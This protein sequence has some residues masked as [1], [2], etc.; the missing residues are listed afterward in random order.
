MSPKTVRDDGPDVERTIVGA[1]FT[2][3]GRQ[4]PLPFLRSAALPGCV[5]AVA[6]AMLRDPRLAPP[7]VNHP[8]EPFWAMFSR[9]L[10]SLDGERHRAMRARFQSLF[11]P[12]QVAAYRAGIERRTR[13]LLDA[14]AGDGEMD[15]VTDF[16]HPLPFGVI[17]EILGVPTERHGWLAERM[18]TIGLGFARQRE[19]E[20]V[21]RASAAA[22]ELQAYYGAELRLRAN[23]A[24]ADS[25]VLSILAANLPDDPE[26]MADIVANCVFFVEAGHATTTALIAGGVLLLLQNPAV[27][28]QLRQE[29][30]LIGNAI[31]EMLRLVSPLAIIPRTPREDAEIAGCPFQ[32]GQTRFVFL[33]GVNR[34][35]DV[36]S[37]PDD[38]ALDRLE[39]RH[40]AFAA[41]PHFCLGA[42]LARLHAEV[43][44]S[45]LLARFPE[46]SLAGEP[47]W[48]GSLPLRQ[49]EALP[50]K[51]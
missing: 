10:V 41:G 23:A 15:V 32:R 37:A 7:G 12:R 16:A 39:N 51:W 35:P 3:E 6:D 5:H 43:A 19:P 30:A 4:D 36:F 21:E 14:R 50:V 20:F 49:L 17:A 27:A 44:I 40:L 13:A 24:T 2:P 33:A 31:E 46:L 28:S 11:V 48:L 8:G 25:D 42:P 34:D 26:A 1:H 9:W 38:F 22:R 29:P 45:A 18:S 47:K